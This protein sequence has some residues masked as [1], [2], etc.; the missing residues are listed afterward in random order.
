MLV[1]IGCRRRLLP[2]EYAAA[3]DTTVR[4]AKMGVSIEQTVILFGHKLSNISSR[5]HLEQLIE[6][7]KQRYSVAA[8]CPNTIRP[9]RRNGVWQRKDAVPEPLRP[10]VHT[11]LICKRREGNKNEKENLSVLLRS[12]RET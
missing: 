10:L 1:F 3:R 4:A 12:G 5:L 8:D 2:P 7:I 11:P 6:N 9:M